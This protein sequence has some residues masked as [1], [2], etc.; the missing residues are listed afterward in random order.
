MD[1]SWDVL[2]AK[3]ICMADRF[4]IQEAVLLATHV[5]QPGS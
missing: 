1:L 3:D 5:S 2:N 4:Y